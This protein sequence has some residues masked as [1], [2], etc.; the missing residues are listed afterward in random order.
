MSAA[1]A[2]SASLA[3][4]D[5]SLPHNN[6]H[7]GVVMRQGFH[8]GSVANGGMR[9]GLS[10]PAVTFSP[11]QHRNQQAVGGGRGVDGSLFPQRDE[12]AL[13]DFSV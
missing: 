10:T 2:G 1:E 7:D 9:L 3:V 11:H 13:S 8:H 5:R 12:S 4:V 6:E